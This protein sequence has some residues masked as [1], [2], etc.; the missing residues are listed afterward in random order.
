MCSAAA[1][2]PH[3]HPVRASLIESVPVTSGPV[4]E[5]KPGDDGRLRDAI[6]ASTAPPS[7]RAQAQDRWRRPMHSIIVVAV[8]R[9]RSSPS[10]ACGTAARVDGVL[11]CLHGIAVSHHHARQRRRWPTM[12]L[13]T[14]AAMHVAATQPLWHDVATAGPCR[15]YICE[16]AQHGWMRLNGRNGRGRRGERE[17]CWG[18]HAH[19]VRAANGVVTGS[20]DA[21]LRQQR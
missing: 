11:C 17:G 21:L 2:Q 5:R 15:G 4:D 13:V 14:V 19:P 10:H 12:P 20:V 3:P 6:S 18:L 7:P 1:A 8:A 9:A 16:I